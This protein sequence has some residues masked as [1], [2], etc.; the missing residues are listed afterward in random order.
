MIDSKNQDIATAGW[1]TLA[2]L[3]SSK[4]DKDLDLNQI[5]NLLDR[6]TT[7]LHDQPDHARYA[8]NSFIIAVGSSIKS[9]TT[10]AIAAAKKIGPVQV[11]MGNTACK[12]PDAAQ[13]INKVKAK[14]A[15]GKKRKSVKC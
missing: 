9:L 6:A 1:N 14:G 11:N 3:V 4:D 15:L 5:K 7:T 12:V 2:G 13:Y 8:M 10:H